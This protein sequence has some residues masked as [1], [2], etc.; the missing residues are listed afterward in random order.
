MIKSFKN[1]KLAIVYALIIV[2]TMM[3]A[4]I[5]TYAVDFTQPSTVNGDG[6]RL[7]KTPGP[8]GIIL[9]LM[10]RGES[11]L[12]SDVIDNNYPAWLYIKRV[13]TGTIG[14]MNWKYFD[15]DSF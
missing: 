13:K 11:I 7:R 10:Y 6:V 9:E 14:W 3:M 15:H 8:D 2:V 1:K 4:P 12:L 5:T